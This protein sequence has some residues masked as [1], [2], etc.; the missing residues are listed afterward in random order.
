M[1]ATVLAG[2]PGIRCVFSDGAS[3]TFLA[4]MIDCDVFAAQ[5]GWLSL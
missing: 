1:P 2:P 4:S 5:W 3:P